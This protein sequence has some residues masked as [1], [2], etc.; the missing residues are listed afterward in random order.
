MHTSF[1]LFSCSLFFI[2]Y[3]IFACSCDF[4]RHFGESYFSLFCFLSFPSF[5]LFLLLQISVWL[6]LK[7][8]TILTGFVLPHEEKLWKQWF[9]VD[10]NFSTQIFFLRQIWIRC[11]CV[12]PVSCL[13]AF[14][15]FFSWIWYLF[16]QN[17]QAWTTE[18]VWTHEQPWTQ[19]LQ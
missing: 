14:K 1:C 4:W 17:L 10:L 11:S 3:K 12:L 7:P 16:Y 18:S 19:N 9:L 5:Y 15:D 8:D 6:I 13:L 2:T